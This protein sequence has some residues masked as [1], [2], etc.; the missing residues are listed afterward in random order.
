MGLIAA[1][2]Q[3]F[4]ILMARGARFLSPRAWRHDLLEVKLDG[5]IPEE[6]PQAGFFKR[7]IGTR[8]AFRD[9]LFALR[10]AKD[11]PNLSA[12][13]FQ[14]REPDIGWARA[15]ELR[16][17]IGE[18]RQA[19]LA[20]AAFLESA[21]NL[22]Y[23]IAAACDEIFLVPSGQVR[24]RG[25]AG[26][27][28]FLKKALDKLGIK[29]EMSHA[30]KYKS[31][32]EMFTRASMSPEHR[33]EVND[34][35]DNI[36]EL[37][38]GEISRDRHISEKRMKALVDRGNFSASEA[39]ESGL[40]DRLCYEDEIKGIYEER[41]FRRP[42]RASLLRY[43]SYRAVDIPLAMH[44]KTR[45][46]I[47]VIYATGPITSGSSSDFSPVGRLAG[48]DSVA[49]SLRMAREDADIAGVMVR[50]DSPGG[51]ALASDL[52]WREMQL[53]VAK[54]KNSDEKTPKPF[55]VSMGDVAASGGY[56]I[57]SSAHKIMAGPSTITGSIGVI[58]G[59]FN[60]GGLA[61]I[62]GVKVETVTRGAVADMES[63]FRGYTQ[64]EKKQLQNEIK[65]VYDDFIK[66]VSTGRSISPKK[67]ERIAQ[68]RV[69]TGAQA[70]EKGLIDSIG[71]FLAAFDE[72]KRS[73]GI[74]VTEKVLVDIYPKKKRV[75][76][77]P[78]HRLNSS[79]RARRQIA[80]TILSLMPPEIRR[81]YPLLRE[82]GPMAI[83]TYFLRIR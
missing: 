27:V 12:V 50:V 59:K 5:D 46:R 8:L 35:L 4:M 14:I 1:A 28:I 63:V 71:G 64:G 48:A 69:W 75:M 25:L 60:V 82:N 23:Y 16:E 61:D 24:I 79:E 58:G 45:P 32:H 13:I 19:G 26:E 22:S 2:I 10:E 38:I 29:A 67:V 15:W 36:Y 9:Y 65:D 52:I 31:A 40:V 37:W 3:I 72:L 42:R 62:L 33:E 73:A 66:R 11:D 54:D 77:L 21:D 74:P 70:L 83:M 57:S 6:L 34:I 76:R 7:I 41:L 39:K 49:E 53:S 47:A 44:F 81:L 17:I 43:V 20:T 68:G 18:L 51:S 80:E 30:G 56:Y 55:I 78:F